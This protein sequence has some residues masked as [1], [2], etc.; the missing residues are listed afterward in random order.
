MLGWIVL[1]LIALAA[2]G[3]LF[4]LFM[5]LVRRPV[6]RISG[7]LHGGFAGIALVVLV[8]LIAVYGGPE[9]LLLNDS[10]VILFMAFCGGGLLYALRATRKPQ[11]LYLIF[12]HGA[13]ALVGVSLLV[14][15]LVRG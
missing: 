6:R 15:G 9:N 10:A 4:L 12:L 14:G 7:P 3:G 1:G 11:P 8:A 2:F 13:M 5:R